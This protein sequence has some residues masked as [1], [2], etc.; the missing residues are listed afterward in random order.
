MCDALVGEMSFPG[1][2][3]LIFA[4]SGNLL[5]EIKGSV[6]IPA[7][8]GF[9]R[10]RSTAL[11]VNILQASCRV[12]I[13]SQILLGQCRDKETNSL[14]QCRHLHA[15]NSKS[16]MWYTDLFKC[17]GTSCSDWEDG[18]SCTHYFTSW[19]W[20][21]QATISS[22]FICEDKQWNSAGY[23]YEN[24]GLNLSNGKPVNGWQPHVD[25]DQG[26]HVCQYKSH[27]SQ[28][29]NSNTRPGTRKLH[30]FS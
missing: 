6:L 23:D 19:N 12:K 2:S 25:V 22:A 30:I 4:S 7:L 1:G 24:E 16:E 14:T 29:P 11:S 8:Q 26:R 18:W 17:P 9:D 27:K 21:A 13:C 5:S 3:S 10:D 15:Q 28:I 20:D